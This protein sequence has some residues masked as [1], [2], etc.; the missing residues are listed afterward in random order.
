MEF[1][2]RFFFHRLNVHF[3]II[4]VVCRKIATGIYPQLREVPQATENNKIK[5]LFFLLGIS[6]ESKYSFRL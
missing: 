5:S 1:G 4:S 6:V 2:S 3:F